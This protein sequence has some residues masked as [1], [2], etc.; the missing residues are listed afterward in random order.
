MDSLFS[1]AKMITPT[2]GLLMFLMGLGAWTWLLMGFYAEYNM[3]ITTETLIIMA[4]GAL[5]LK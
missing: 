4:L 1:F 2:I 3:I 5:I